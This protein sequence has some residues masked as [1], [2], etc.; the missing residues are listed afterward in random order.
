M[1]SGEN[2]INGITKRHLYK[3]RQFKIGDKVQCVKNGISNEIYKSIQVGKTYTII[4]KSLTF[5]TWRWNGVDIIDY[6]YQLDMF[7]EQ[8]II[9]DGFENISQIREDK[10]NQILN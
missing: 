6:T 5:D 4:N 8:W 3:E 9:L 7:P 1:N 10:L 2:E